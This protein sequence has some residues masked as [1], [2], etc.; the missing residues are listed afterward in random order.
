MVFNLQ[1]DV[2]FL[3]IGL[4]AQGYRRFCLAL[5]GKV[6]GNCVG[7]FLIF[8]RNLV[9][10]KLAIVFHMYYWY[11]YTHIFSFIFVEVNRKL[12]RCTRSTAF[13]FPPKPIKCAFVIWHLFTVCTNAFVTDLHA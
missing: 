1:G 6:F 13:S 11:L 9:Y 12:Y 5:H 7:F 2:T 4:E 8:G 3:I 10:V